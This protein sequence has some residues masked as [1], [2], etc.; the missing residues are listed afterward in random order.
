MSGHGDDRD[1]GEHDQRNDEHDCGQRP[2]HALRIWIERRQ[3]GRRHRRERVVPEL[4][5]RERRAFEP[6]RLQ[7]I[8]ERD[9]VAQGE[10][11]PAEAHG[12]GE[13][14]QLLDDD[15]AAEGPL[16]VPVRQDHQQRK[17]RRR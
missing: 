5:Q 1:D 9:I 14:R 7:R 11:Q 13:K 8:G 2:C 17:D 3:A 16:A 4:I 10:G 6:R 15:R 12:H